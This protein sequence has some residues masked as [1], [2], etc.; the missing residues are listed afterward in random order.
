LKVGIDN[1]SVT[2]ELSDASSANF[3]VV[4][5]YDLKSSSFIT[6]V[7]NK[8]KLGALIKIELGYI[9]TRTQVFSGYI[10]NVSMAFND[11]P[12]I[13]VTALDVRGLMRMNSRSNYQ[14]TETKYSE[15]TK[16]VLGAYKKVCPNLKVDDTTK[17]DLNIMQNGT[18]LDFIRD[19]LGQKAKKEFLVIDDTAYFRDFGNKKDPITTLK[20]GEGL[21]SFS[22]SI[23][24]CNEDIKVYGHSEKQN[25]AIEAKKTVKSDSKLPSLVTP[26]PVREIPSSDAEDKDE[27]TKIVEFE[28]NERKKKSQNGSGTC[29][30]LPEI[31]PG[32]YIKINNLDS[33]LNKAY[34]LNQVTHNFGGDGY[35]TDFEIG[36]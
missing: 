32:R 11:M 29:I 12:S 2:L 9:S 18:D 23:T 13:K 6:N 36:G 27:A 24:Y 8:L 33:S 15:V 3:T 1:L 30:G 16:K 4:N 21:L 35:T 25:Q 7:K 17:E 5:V 20:W 34:Y 26:A 31:I 14:F 10:A 19:V 22:S 28:I